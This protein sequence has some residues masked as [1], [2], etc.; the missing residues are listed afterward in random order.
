MSLVIR[1]TIKT[2]IQA[3]LKHSPF[4]PRFRAI[5][6]LMFPG[7]G[8][9]KVGMCSELR[10]SPAASKLIA[11][12]E[13]TTGVNMTALFNSQK[14]LAIPELCMLAMF[15]GSLAKIEQ[16]KETSSCLIK[17]TEAVGS[18]GMGVYAALVFTE[19]LDFNNA[20]R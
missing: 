15:I 7:T 17:D 16:L 18:L 2:T 12:A 19:A 8:A 14:D 6:L 5:S 9:E 4:H 3:N 1:H 10:H 20:L 13:A 11:G